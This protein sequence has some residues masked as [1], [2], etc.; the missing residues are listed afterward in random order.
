[1]D[2]KAFKA[3]TKK[4]KPPQGI[5]PALEAMWYQAKGDWDTAHRLAKSQKNSMG[6]WVHAYLHRVEGDKGNAAYWYRLAEKPVCTSRLDDEW[7]E[8]V[9]ALV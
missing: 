4:D 3:S 7:E 8:I 5:P 1:M 9:E 6:N 2:L